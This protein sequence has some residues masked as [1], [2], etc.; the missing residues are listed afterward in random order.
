MSTQSIVDNQ[1]RQLEHLVEQARTAS[2]FRRAGTVVEISG[3]TIVARGPAAQIGELCALQI[4]GKDDP[5]YAQVVAF[6]ENQTI[7][8]A[9]GSLQGVEPGCR[10][11]AIGQQLQI[12]VGPQMPGRVVD[13]F[14]RALDDQGPIPV[15]SHR[16]LE[17][18]P[19]PPLKR[20]RITEPLW[21]GVRAI[22]GLL[23]CC[24]GQRLGIFAGAGV[25]KSMLLGMIARNSSAD[26]NVIALV[27]ERGREV[28][29]F[30]ERD[31]GEGLAKSVVVVTTSDQPPLL[32]VHTG[33]AATT[34][35]EYFRDQGANVLLLMDSLTRLARAQREVGLAVGE[36]PTTGGY[37][38]S[39]YTMLP[40]LLERAG[41]TPQ[42]TITGFYTVLVEQDDIYDAVGD[43][44]SAILDGRIVLSRELA[45]AGHYP[46]IDVTRSVS[47]LMDDV[48]EAD[49]CQAAAQFRSLLAARNEAQDLIDVGAYTR[50]SDPRVDRALALRSEMNRFLQQRPN[51][52]TAPDRT[53]QQLIEL[54]KM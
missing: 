35:A 16:A 33:L 12:G 6:R 26:V 18:T 44:A 22:D 3:L 10:V 9:L 25:G 17:N 40:R 37:P 27:G 50:G 5:I 23:T 24:Q 21:V 49:H 43:A 46:A 42:G 8:L 36:T 11:V 38:P 54:M 30:L 28:L 39:L 32:R 41:A 52:Y 53:R 2:R 51:E 31:L 15:H 4:G 14:G 29:D 20:R 13:C 7:L 45:E 47:R 1:V 19:P 48:V 34:I